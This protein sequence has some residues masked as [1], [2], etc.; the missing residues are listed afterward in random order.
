M[1]KGFLL[2]LTGRNLYQAFIHQLK[3]LNTQ[4]KMPNM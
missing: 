1:I 3:V 2:D 4:Q